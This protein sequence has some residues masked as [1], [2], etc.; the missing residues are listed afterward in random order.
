MPRAPEALNHA[1]QQ[2]ERGQAT[3]ID[4]IETLLAEEI[5]IRESRRITR[6]RS[7]AGGAQRL[8]RLSQLD[9]DFR[10]FAPS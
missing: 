1:D 5:T 9:P 3:A 6:R 8:P 7:G 2:L 10:N 4:A